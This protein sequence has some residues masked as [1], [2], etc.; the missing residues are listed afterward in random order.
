MKK[1][2]EKNGCSIH[3]SLLEIIPTQ[4]DLTNSEQCLQFKNSP[5][6]NR[7]LAKGAE[8]QMGEDIYVIKH[9]DVDCQSN[10]LYV[11]KKSLSISDKKFQA[12]RLVM[13]L[14][15]DGE[16]S[17]FRIYIL[18]Y[19]VE[20]YGFVCYY[21]HPGYAYSSGTK[22]KKGNFSIENILANKGIRRG[23]EADQIDEELIKQKKI[24]K[25]ESFMK[26]INKNSFCGKVTKIVNVVMKSFLP[27]FKRDSKVFAILGCD[28][29][30]DEQFNCFWIDPNISARLGPWAQP[31]WESAI[32]L[33]IGTNNKQIIPI[34]GKYTKMEQS[35]FSYKKTAVHGTGEWLCIFIEKNMNRSISC[36]RKKT[37]K[38]N[39]RR[40]RL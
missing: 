4:Y 17:T 35:T 15:L 23:W 29:L 7:Y 1:L 26:L 16:V 2:Y 5:N 38:R 18:I 22:F 12:Q 14:L 30:V 21:Y 9:D 33:V 3:N 8:S 36:K 34:I 24:K 32:N 27:K 25:G 10:T 39:T 37:A 31:Q 28:I 13:P 11:D 19:Y 20:K 6:S 40:R